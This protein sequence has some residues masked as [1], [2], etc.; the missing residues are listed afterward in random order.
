MNSSHLQPSWRQVAEQFF[1]ALSD[2]QWMEAATLVDP[3]SASLFRERQLA[4]LVGWA[5]QLDALKAWRKRAEGGSF[6]WSSNGI[7]TSE[8]LAATADTTLAAVPGVTTL[9]ELASL[10][11]AAFIA[12]YFEVS[13]S[14]DSKAG[15]AARRI[16]GGVAEGEFTVHVLY[17]DESP[18]IT[19]SDPYHVDHLRLKRN[20]NDWFVDLWG[21]PEFASGHDVMR[22]ADDFFASMERNEDLHSDV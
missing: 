9:G 16:L 15:V 20:S 12:K 21:D 19:Y 17:R 2:A 18:G 5:Q 6:G 7:V 3:A 10:S 1:Q 22:L 8:R 4:S 14:P 11:A 13:N